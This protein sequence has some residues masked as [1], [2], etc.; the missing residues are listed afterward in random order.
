MKTGELE[1]KR[2]RMAAPCDIYEED[3]KILI[4]LDMPGVTRENLSVHMENDELQITGKRSSPDI[5]NGKYLV[6][7]IPDADFY[8]AYTVDRTIDRDKIEAVLSQGRLHISL[9]IRE[10][11]KPRKIQITNRD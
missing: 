4:V 11:E 7:E 1:T 2:R 9:S 10:S 6:R 3:G 5:R 8:Q